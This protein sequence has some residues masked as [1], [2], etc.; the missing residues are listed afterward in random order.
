MSSNSVTTVTSDREDI[1]AIIGINSYR[2]MKSLDAVLIPNRPRKVDSY[3]RI[4]SRPRQ[5]V[6]DLIIYFQNNPIPSGDLD[7]YWYNSNIHHFLKDLL[8]MFRTDLDVFRLLQI[9]NIR[10]IIFLRT[11]WN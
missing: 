10:N 1:D 6:I 7:P 4:G 11:D 8:R 9:P 3:L 5:T 2:F